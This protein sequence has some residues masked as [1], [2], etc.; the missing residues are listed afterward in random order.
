MT[1]MQLKLESQAHLNYVH[2]LI[3]V[4]EHLNLCCH[5]TIISYNTLSCE[6]VQR[7]DHII[8]LNPEGGMI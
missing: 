5:A 2:T 7:D 3:Q 6:G 4:S 8:P 1:C